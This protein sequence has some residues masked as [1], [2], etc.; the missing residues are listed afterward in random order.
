MHEGVF[1][2]V[3]PQA[4]ILIHRIKTVLHPV[5][6]PEEL[7]VLH[8]AP[9]S[10]LYCNVNPAT[11]DGELV[12]VN[13]AA[14]VLADDN[15]GVAGISGYT[16]AIADPLVQA[17]VFAA[18]LPQAASLLHRIKIV[19]HPG[20]MPEELVVPHDVPL[21]KLYWSVKPATGAGVLV[22]VIAVAQVLIADKVGVAGVA[23]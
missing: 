3:D 13:A 23:G 2:A 19:L 8:D 10:K 18:I 22:I 5:A 17:A 15:V 4:A 14:Q 9:L 21:S 20:V 1:A 6:V 11:A 12:T 7:V 16:R